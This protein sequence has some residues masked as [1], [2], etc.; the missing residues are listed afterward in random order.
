MHA[1]SDQDDEEEDE[2]ND[3]DEEEEEGF[4]GTAAAPAPALAHRSLKE[5]VQKRH[6]K[7][8]ASGTVSPLVDLEEFTTEQG[9]EYAL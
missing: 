8:R 3:E 6:E 2:E 5:L 1:V 9:K 4:D 7:Q